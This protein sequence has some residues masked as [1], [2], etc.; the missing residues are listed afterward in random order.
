MYII[1]F[2]KKEI[3]S[4]LQIIENK[5]VIS[6]GF[7]DGLKKFPFFYE[8]L[9]KIK[10]KI[11]SVY[12]RKI[13][14]FIR[15]HITKIKTLKILFLAS[16]IVIFSSCDHRAVEVD[17]ENSSIIVKGDDKIEETVISCPT[18]KLCFI[19]INEYGET[20]KE[21]SELTHSEIQDIAQDPLE[22]FVRTKKSKEKELSAEDAKKE[23]SEFASSQDITQGIL[24]YQPN[25]ERGL[26][27]KITQISSYLE[28][29]ENKKKSNYFYSVIE[30]EEDKYHNFIVY[31]SDS[32]NRAE[33]I[34]IIDELNKSYIEELTK[35]VPRSQL[36]DAIKNLNNTLD[37]TKDDD[38]ST[39]SG[40]VPLIYPDV[41]SIV[42]EYKDKKG[43]VHIFTSPQFIIQGNDNRDIGETVRHEGMHAIGDFRKINKIYEILYRILQPGK[44]FTL[45]NFFDVYTENILTSDY[46]R[47]D[48]NKIENTKF[49]M[50]ITLKY[51]IGLGLINVFK[52]STGTTYSLTRQYT[53]GNANEHARRLFDLEYAITKVTNQKIFDIVKF[54]FKN[55]YSLFSFMNEKDFIFDMIDYQIKCLDNVGMVP[56]F[57]NEGYINMQAVRSSKNFLKR[58]VDNNI[59]RK[60]RFNLLYQITKLQKEDLE[61]IKKAIT[62]ID[63]SL[64]D[65]EN[66]ALVEL[67]GTLGKDDIRKSQNNFIKRAFYLANIISKY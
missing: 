48:K 33:I 27:E 37:K 43:D 50:K 38:F 5:Y 44:K 17:I 49:V 36:S 25:I 9:L 53:A 10:E 63:N 52:D 34:K 67:R 45:K 22:P 39:V 13:S 26:K 28:D 47:Y 20:E 21:T 35:V 12:F 7:F 32:N 57:N 59:F 23:F 41:S 4:L 60:E 24:F 15:R 65:I 54:F 42:F 64:K 29:E 61:K 8:K 16:S 2:D 46:Y 11:N 58:Y 51:L 14:D 1:N 6:E 19:H 30:D 55:Y 40:F 62:V 31:I 18:K 3:H 56:L 66:A